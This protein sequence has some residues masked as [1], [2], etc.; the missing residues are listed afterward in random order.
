MRGLSGLKRFPEEE[1]ERTN[2]CGSKFIQIPS[3]KSK[4]P[5]V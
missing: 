3:F 1:N 2:D 5:D 4:T